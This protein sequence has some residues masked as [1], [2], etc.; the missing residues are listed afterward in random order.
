VE[1]YGSSLNGIIAFQF[2]NHLRGLMKSVKKA[3]N[4][5]SQVAKKISRNGKIKM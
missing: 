1:H 5:I 4:S 3:Q 2:E